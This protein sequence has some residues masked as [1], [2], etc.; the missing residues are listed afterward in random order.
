MTKYAANPRVSYRKLAFTLVELLVVIGIIAILVGI[1]L[2][3]LGR[4]RA[5]ARSL[6][7]MSN[8]RSLGQAV[9]MYVNANKQSLPWG[10]YQ[11]TVPN[12]NTR[13]YMLLQNTLASKY[14]TTWGDAFATSAAAAKIRELFM[15]P[16]APGYSLNRSTNGAIHYMCH[17]RLMPDTTL[18]GHP[19]GTPSGTVNERPY[20]MP[21]IRRASEVALLFDGPLVLNGENWQVLWDVAV[22]NQMDGQGAW[23]AEHFTDVYST[24]G[25]SPDDSV[26]MRPIAGVGTAGPPNSDGGGNVQNIRFRHMKDAKANAL[27]VDGHVETFTYNPKKAVDDK[28]VTDFKR[29]N[30]YVNP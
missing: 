4:A 13:W 17:P 26:S 11:S 29:K 20:K 14:G 30:L 2:P 16:E 27:M 28:S 22:A 6:Q 7:C 15:C 19:F 10:E 3:T 23:A 21:K 8:L 12:S 9:H 24:P 5:S 1:L 25:K 18:P